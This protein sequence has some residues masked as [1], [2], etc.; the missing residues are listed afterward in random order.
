MAAYRRLTRTERANAIS[1]PSGIAGR[2]LSPGPHGPAV[3]VLRPA[4]RNFRTVYL[5]VLPV[6][7]RKTTRAISVDPVAETAVQTAL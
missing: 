3:C 4:G 1:P 7:K 5:T 6:A 2:D